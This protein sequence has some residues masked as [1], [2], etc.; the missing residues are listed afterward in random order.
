M[1][2]I[3]TLITLLLSLFI[4]GAQAQLQG[5][6]LNS[7]QS[8]TGM[9][10]LYNLIP[11]VVGS[12]QTG[13]NATD[14]VTGQAV[15]EDDGT[16]SEQEL[17][18]VKQLQGVLFDAVLDSLR[19]E[20]AIKTDSVWRSDIFG[21]QFFHINKL[22]LFSN[23]ERVKAPDNY[24]LDVGDELSVSVWGASSYNANVEIGEDGYISLPDGGRIY[25]KGVTY[26]AAKQLVGRRLGTF[27]DTR[28]SN[29]EIVLNYS[30]NITVNIVGDVAKPGSYVIPAIN[31]VFN[32]L[33][34]ATPTG[35]G[36]V[37]NIEVKRNG[38]VVKQ[39][40]L[41][42]FL[43]DGEVTNDF[44]LQD[45]DYIYVPTQNKVVE[46]EGSVRRPWK[47]EMLEDETL[48]DLIEM[49]G[50]LNAKSY[51]SSIQIKRFS[52]TE[53]ELINI[54]LDTLI[55]GSNDTLVDGDIIFIPQIP[56]DYKNFVNVEGAVRFPG[57][58]QLKEGHRI[59]D[60][61][62]AAGGLDFDAYLQRAYITR[63]SE[64]LSTTIQ[65]FNLSSVV[66]DGG[67][68]EDVLLQRSDKIEVFSK[69][70]F[71]EDFNV[72][73][74]GAVLKP[75]KIQF[76]EGMTLNDLIFYAGGLKKEA[77]NNVIEIS[78]VAKRES[79]GEEVLMRVIVNTVNVTADLEIDNA[80]KGLE[81]SP[82]DQVFVRKNP[83]FD[84]Q[85]NIMIKGEVNYPGRYPI[86]QKDE[87]IIDLI[88]RAGGLTPYAFIQSAKL[89]RQDETIG[90]V[91]IDLEEAYRSPDSR[92]NYIL[93]PGDVIEIPTVN[94]LVSVSG[95]I[96]HP[97]L[98]SLATI[99]SFYVPGKRAKYYVKGFAGGYDKK[100][101]KRS[102]MVVNPD[103]SAGYT[104]KVLFFN[105][106]PEVKEGASV[107]VQ[108]KKSSER[109]KSKAE[110]I[111][112]PLNWN[113]LLPS[114]VVGATS[115][116]SSTILILLLNKQ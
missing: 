30:R 32:A 64:D 95:A 85:D 50:G 97:Q 51:V 106:Y 20:T 52:G 65:K 26:G 79:N 49:A 116:I 90:V 36:S 63:K 69:K 89:Y 80:S 109:Q 76:S 66:I 35:I 58:Y 62:T 13:Q 111:R 25:L 24:T 102:T 27:I 59:S 75:V 41:Y 10:D 74:E 29:T 101:K 105:R 81:L 37:R 78:R 72:L 17:Y 100:A 82:M 104:K 22:S 43:L 67:S 56:E 39:F 40:D 5:L 114:V 70:E 68:P 113:I 92:P 15:G 77:A 86:L 9:S 84:R 45:G 110:T 8:L 54:D 108:Y 83:D 47:Y 34:A 4:S 46:I 107:S 53:V 14:P 18:Y 48:A 1:K 73:I 71:L 93:K 3:A 19:G 31:S 98:D 96:G 16:L 112:E 115:V 28:S 91:V 61:I 103:G 7:L 6:N 88:E 38:V 44:F 60:A 94:Q 2:R 23:S 99:S 12:A 21:H 42:K 87:K 57:Q 11:S 55:A 33:N